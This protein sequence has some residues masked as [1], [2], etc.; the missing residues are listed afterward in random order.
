[1]ANT[2]ACVDDNAQLRP[3]W[4]TTTEAADRIRCTRKTIYNM[5]DDGRLTRHY[6]GSRVLRIDLNEIDAILAGNTTKRSA[7]LCVT[8]TSGRTNQP[9]QGTSTR[10]TPKDKETDEHPGY[11]KHIMN[12]DTGNDILRADAVELAEHHWNV[13]P[14]AGQIPLIP[15]RNPTGTLFN[16]TP[17]MKGTPSSGLLTLR[18]S[19]SHGLRRI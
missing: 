2:D 11:V 4:G 10:E 1:M 7:P 16:P 15:N 14:L 19:R 3:H 17:N 12:T 6:L 18:K 13:F 9:G 8:S 5:C